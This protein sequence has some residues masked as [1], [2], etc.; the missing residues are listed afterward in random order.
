MELNWQ[1]AQLSSIQGEQMHI[2]WYNSVSRELGGEPILLSFAAML[3]Q[4]LTF[5][6]LICFKLCGHIYNTKVGDFKNKYEI[7]YVL[8]VNKADASLYLSFSM[9]TFYCVKFTNEQ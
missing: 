6:F 4:L 9:C 2:T 1:R 5:Y 8:P 3:T 7:L